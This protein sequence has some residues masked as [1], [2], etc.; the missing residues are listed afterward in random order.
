MIGVFIEE[1][2]GPANG[3]YFAA[4]YRR[5][6]HLVGASG[7]RRP[8][9][10]LEAVGSVVYP[11]DWSTNPDGG[12]RVAHLSSVDAIVLPLVLLEQS[13][14]VD[15][16][17]VLGNCWVQ[18]V[19]LRS[20]SVPWLELDRVPLAVEI[21]VY[22]HTLVVAAVVG[23]IR[24][25]LTLSTQ[26]ATGDARRETEWSPPAG[27]TVYGGL[28]RNTVSRTLLTAYKA[29]HQ[30]LSAEHEFSSPASDAR[31][32]GGLESVF[33]PALTAVD[34]LVTMGQLTQVAIYESAQTSRSAA[35][36]L[37]MRTMQLRL[38]SPPTRVPASLHTSTRLVRDRT[39]ART[40]RQLHDVLVDSMAS[41]GVTARAALAY[42]E[43]RQL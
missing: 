25:R 3:R 35:G 41:S 17:G 36:N 10:P 31:T 9:H 23:N 13:D 33:W 4:G 14:P 34:Y 29:T 39:L 32:P 24:A 43:A 2:L 21:D 28:Y 38:P 22:G 37:W 40:G 7:R 26:N 16:P 30:T 15:F 19:D 42:E 1:A 18:C 5:V 8:G 6:S 20:G 12:A 11:Q 27:S